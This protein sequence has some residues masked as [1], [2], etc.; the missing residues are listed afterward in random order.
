VVI[1]LRAAKALALTIPPLMRKRADEM[2]GVRL[3]TVIGPSRQAAFFG[4]TVDNGALRTWLDLQLAQP[5][6]D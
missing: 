6:L 1:N 2:I 5:N 3:M 4:P